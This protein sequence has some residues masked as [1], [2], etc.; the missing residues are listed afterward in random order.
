MPG[1]F[2]SYMV[3]I[4]FLLCG[5]TLF[6]Q[7]KDYIYDHYNISNGLISDN[8]FKIF[9]DRSGYIWIITYN[10]LQ[11]YDGYEFK[12]YTSDPAIEGTLSSNFV[13]DIFEDRDGV[14][15]NW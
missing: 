15:T 12:T 4:V 1:R 5:N 3:T 8:V 9:T 6:S 13:V 14:T 10:G 2:V 7:D 11:K